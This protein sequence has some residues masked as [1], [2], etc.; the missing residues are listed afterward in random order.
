MRIKI[1]L[2]KFSSVYIDA[3]IIDPENENTFGFDAHI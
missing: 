3:S 2:L 1:P